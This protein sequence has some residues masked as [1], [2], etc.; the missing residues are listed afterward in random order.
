MRYTRGIKL[1]VSQWGQ[2][3]ELEI[4]RICLQRGIPIRLNENA[5][6]EGD[7]KE[8]GRSL[9]GDIGDRWGPSREDA[10]VINRPLIGYEEWRALEGRYARRKKHDSLRRPKE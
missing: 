3:A 9:L 8:F 2:M 10:D 4:G 6:K 5:R 7:L 1:K